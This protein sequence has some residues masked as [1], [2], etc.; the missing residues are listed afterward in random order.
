MSHK[1][2]QEMDCVLAER[3][4]ELLLKYGG[5]KDERIKQI[6]EGLNS[7]K[8]EVSTDDLFYLMEKVG[9]S[10]EAVR[11]AANVGN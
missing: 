5:D 3:M 11:A 1:Q 8:E 6:V 4:N 10:K 9:V 7:D 2:K